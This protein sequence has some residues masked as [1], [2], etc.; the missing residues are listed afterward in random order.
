[1][2]ALISLY[3]QSDRFIT[4]ENLSTAIDEAFTKPASFG[5]DQGKHSLAEIFQMRK[6]QR[7]S[8]KFF[9]GKD[10]NSSSRHDSESMGPGWTE[11]KPKRVDRIYQALMGTH[12]DGTPSWTAVKENAERVKSQIDRD[13]RV[14]K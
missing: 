5:D 1:M 12:K 3:H 6:H 4:P 13:T 7:E 10:D 14:R 2:E 9:L 11:S 8:P